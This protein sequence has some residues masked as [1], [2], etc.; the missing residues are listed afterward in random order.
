MMDSYSLSWKLEKK[1]HFD[2]KI[3]WFCWFFFFIFSHFVPGIS[4]WA[5][6]EDGIISL[7]ACEKNNRWLIFSDTRKMPTLGS[8]ALVAR[9]VSHWN[10]W[11]SGW[12]FPV[13]T[14]QQRWIRFY[15][16]QESTGVC[17]N[18]IFYPMVKSRTSGVQENIRSTV[19]LTGLDSW[20]LL[21]SRLKTLCRK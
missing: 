5:T 18:K 4:V 16:R 9:L 11:P 3:S 15:R 19:W 12:D 14:E 8:T 10:V 13:P 2:N 1:E 17:E 7:M 20:S 21:C 6:R